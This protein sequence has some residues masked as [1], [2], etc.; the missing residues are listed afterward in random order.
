MVEQYESLNR[1]SCQWASA[2]VFTVVSTNILPLKMKVLPSCPSTDPK[3]VAD[4]CA[5][6]A[7]ADVVCCR[8]VAYRILGFQLGYDF[9]LPEQ[10]FLG[11]FE[12][13]RQVLLQH[14]AALMLCTQLLLQLSRLLLDSQR[15][16]V[17]RHR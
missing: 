4:A 1:R 10:G 11:V 14:H 17:F 6:V 8:N 2:T 16:E 12:A 5:D 9:L 13:D 7:F 3:G 15:T